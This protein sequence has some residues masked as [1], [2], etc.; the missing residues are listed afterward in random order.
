MQDYDKKLDKKVIARSLLYIIYS[1]GLL[2]FC[3]II[4]EHLCEN[5]C[6]GFF[7][8]PDLNFLESAGLLAFAYI[9]LFGII[10]IVNPKLFTTK[11]QVTNSQEAVKMSK[12]EEKQTNFSSALSSLKPQDKNKLRQIIA[13]KY[14]FEEQN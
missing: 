3:A 13:K 5:N 1:G 14:G 11:R 6:W 4:L 10:H 9:I 12:S 7:K 2:T 8:V